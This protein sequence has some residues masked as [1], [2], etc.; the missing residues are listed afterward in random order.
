MLALLLAALTAYSY[1]KEPVTLGEL[2]LTRPKIKAF[3]EGHKTMTPA[4]AKPETDSGNGKAEDDGGES[5]SHGTAGEN[6]NIPEVA[7]HAAAPPRHVSDTAPQRILMIGES[8]IEGIFLRFKHDYEK[9]NGHLIKAQI[10]YGSSTRDWAKNDSL[11]KVIR[12]FKPTLVFVSIG[13]NELSVRDLDR[14]EEA[15]LNILD[16]LKGTRFIWVGPPNWKKDSGIGEL[17]EKH[18]PADQYF[19]SR[20]LQYKRRKDGAHPR[21]ESCNMWADTLAKWVMA[22]SAYPIR[23][24]LPPDKQPY[25]ATPKPIATQAP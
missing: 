6:D 18:I 5:P 19:L 24:N 16:Q 7:V 1:F 20:N 15:I 17:L 4:Q 23:L 10:W 3:V 12:W 25:P 14:R 8:M 13:G 11:R 22:K 21:P 9:Y 2:E